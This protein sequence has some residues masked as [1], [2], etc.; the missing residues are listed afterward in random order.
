MSGQLFAFEQASGAWVTPPPI[1][2]HSEAPICDTC[3]AQVI[4]KGPPR[5]TLGGWYYAVVCGC[6]TDDV[7]F[8]PVRLAMGG[9]RQFWEA[10]G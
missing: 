9:D 3:G 7:L 8:F 6:G 10:R 4:W 5:R 1:L 2:F